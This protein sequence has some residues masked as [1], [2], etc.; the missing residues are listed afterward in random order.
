MVQVKRKQR[1]LMV[2]MKSFDE[3]SPHVSYPRFCVRRNFVDKKE[4]LTW[5]LID[6]YLLTK[7]VIAETLSNDLLEQ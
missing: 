6:T 2:Y 3:K 4:T 1:D 5:F 7:W